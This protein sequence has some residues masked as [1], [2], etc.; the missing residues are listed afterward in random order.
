MNQPTPLVVVAI[1]S[2]TG[3]QSGKSTYL[4][5]V[6]RKIEPEAVHLRFSEP[7]IE[8][9]KTVARLLG[10]DAD[11]EELKSMEILPGITGRQ[12]M[13]TVGDTVRRELR[14]SFYADI[15]TSRLRRIGPTTRTVVIDDFR[16]MPEVDAL[17]SSG[18]R[19]QFINVLKPGGGTND[20]EFK[21]QTLRDIVAAFDDPFRIRLAEVTWNGHGSFETARSKGRG[22]GWPETERNADGR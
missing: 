21:A 18:A 11:Y 22:G 17:L 19:V 12:F 9:L 4:E 3:P 8:Y 5:K 20:C 6:V 10:I 13:V 7:I 15:L 14:E 16:K 2:T 1:C